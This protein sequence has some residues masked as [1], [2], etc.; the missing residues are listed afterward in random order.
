MPLKHATETFLVVLLGLIVLLTGCIAAFLP[1]LDQ[2]PI[3]WGVVFILSVVYALLLHPL[4]RTRRADNSF[5][6]LHYFPAL[7]L[8]VWFVL[9]FFRESDP[10]VARMEELFL[11]GWTMP[12]VIVGFVLLAAYCLEVIRQRRARLTF[13]ILLLVPFAVLAVSAQRLQWNPRIVAALRTVE[14][15]TTLR[16]WG[17]V[18]Q[19]SSAQQSSQQ[20]WQ[21]AQRRMERRGERLAQENSSLQM[22]GAKDAGLNPIAGSAGTQMNVKGTSTSKHPAV[23]RKTPPKLPPSG[24]GT[25]VAIPLV[26]ACYTGVVHLRAK[27]R[28]VKA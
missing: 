28:V 3:L 6:L 12:A 24:F 11:W 1:P 13:L 20:Q 19:P 4:F 26:L 15:V 21:M 8:L 5:R 18:Q 7:I 2:N 27:R 22:E 25:E 10:T 17:I 16:R 23:I 14:P 9:E